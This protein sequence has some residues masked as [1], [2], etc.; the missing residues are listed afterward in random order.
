[1]LRQVKL[2]I[3]DTLSFHLRDPHLNGQTKKRIV[4]L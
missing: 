4:D 1:M 2:I 3:I